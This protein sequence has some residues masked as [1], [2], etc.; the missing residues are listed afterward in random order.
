MSTFCLIL[1]LSVHMLF[2][3][4]IQ[5]LSHTAMFVMFTFDLFFYLT[6]I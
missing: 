1:L 2:A 6:V 4:V 5:R 3:R